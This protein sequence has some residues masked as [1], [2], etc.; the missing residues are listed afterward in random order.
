MMRHF[1]LAAAL[2][3]VATGAAGADEVW[4]TD[5]GTEVIYETDLDGIGTAVLTFDGVSLYVE[6][7]AGVH[8]GRGTY[9]GVWFADDLEAVSYTHLTLPTTPYV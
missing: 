3:V 1:L 7:L 9:S 6:G 2:T 4:R 8:E 5:D